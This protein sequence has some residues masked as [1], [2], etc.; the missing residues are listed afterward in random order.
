MPPGRPVVFIAG[1]NE[2]LA[3][4]ISES[5][6]PEFGFER[7]DVYQ[8][9]IRFVALTHGLVERFPSGN[10]GLTEQLRRASV[11]I[12]LNIAE[13]A[14]RTGHGDVKRHRT[15]ARG[16]AMECA[17]I[18]DVCRALKLAPPEQLDDARAL[19]IRIVQ[20][21]TKMCR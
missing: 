8:A 18:L 14:G 1:G 16:S 9:A 20:M 21:L 13:G 11:S 12:P 3:A 15:I 5:M 2:G 17:A 6:G 10:S 4:P 19:L 7:L